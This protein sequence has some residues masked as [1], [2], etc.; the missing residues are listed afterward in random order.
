MKSTRK[1]LFV[2][3]VFFFLSPALSAQNWEIVGE[4]ITAGN[5]NAVCFVDE[6]TA[7][8]V[9]QNASMFKS[10]DKGLT[11]SK[12]NLEA[13]VQELWAIQFPT[14]ETGY[15]SG[16]SGTLLKT[17]DAGDTWTDISANLPAN[18]QNGL[19]LGLHFKN[20]DNGFIVGNPGLILQTADGGATWN[21]RNNTAADGYLRSIHFANNTTA[22]AAG[23]NG[24]IKI[25]TDGGLTWQ[26]HVPAE[27]PSNSDPKTMLCFG[28][29]LSG[30]EFGGIYPGTY[31]AHYAYPTEAD[32]DYFKSKNLK[33]IRF[34]FRWE[35]IQHTLDGPLNDFDLNLMKDFI[36]AAE[37]RNMPVIPDMHNF[38]R[39]SVNGQQIVIATQVTKEQ[40]GNCW[41]Q[42]ATEFKSYNNIWAYD[43]M[44]EPYSM[45]WRMD[46]YDIAQT[47][48]DSIRAVDMETMIMVS[49]DRF[50]SPY[51]WETFNDSLYKL[52]DPAN[53]LIFQAHLY[54]DD[55]FSGEYQKTNPDGSKSSSTYEEEGANPQTGVDR[56]RPF[57]EWV[58]RH[59][60]RGFVG[61]Y[62]IPADAADIDKWAIVL[63]N[64]LQ[65]LSDNKIPGT[66][67]S[68]GPRWGAYRLAV[69]PSDNYTTDR[70]QMQT[71]E[72]FTDIQE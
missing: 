65:Y 28:V 46:W 30:G 72:K 31:N 15:A 9:G 69:Q 32:L 66:Y 25:S 34:P 19:L 55:D 67:W 68:A 17:N 23:N 18:A 2:I 7:F 41:K 10:E 43:I 27:K 26:D 36:Q 3:P 56:M 49:G 60:V 61:E 35:R 39:R 14:P 47:V 6:E 53:N 1:Y 21:S 29:N 54:F 37:D 20:A 42:L 40:L 12:V 24:K 11:W 13:T 52:V 70:P 38:G 63:E 71:L 8:A 4:G 62:G 57:V 64:M 50:S 51:H 16:A 33:L 44:N 22:Y 59:N 58:K 5:L 48:I 45:S